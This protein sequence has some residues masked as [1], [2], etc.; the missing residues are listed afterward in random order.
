MASLYAEYIKEWMGHEIIENECGFASYSFEPYGC[1]IR[2]I[3]VIPE[4]R[5]TKL[6]S[7][8]AD[9]IAEIA[10]SQGVRK[11]F[12]TVNLLSKSST[13]SLKVLLAYGF[14]VRNCTEDLIMMEKD[15]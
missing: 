1:Y 3:F 12:G 2:D 10:R 8:M 6:A 13:E 5:K 9:E 7:R 15:I 14:R 4:L 11:L